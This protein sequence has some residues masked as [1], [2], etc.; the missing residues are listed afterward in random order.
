MALFGWILFTGLFLFFVGF[1]LFYHRNSNEFQIKKSLIWSMLCCS[2]AFLFNL[3]I[4]FFKG[5][6][7]ALE[8]TTGYLVEL[9]L[10]IDNIFVFLLI[11]QHFNIAVQYQHKILSCGVIGALLLRL[12]FILIGLELIHTFHWVLYLFGIFLIVT[13]AAMLKK[14]P[15]KV[16]MKDNFIL[17]I[18]K[19]FF[20][21]QD[22]M[23][24]GYFF[25]RKNGA[26]IATPLFAVLLSVETADLL[27]AFD[28]IPAIFG[29]TV[30]PFIVLTSNGFAV[31]G[32]RSLYFTLYS[33]LRLF[34]YLRHGICIILMFIG[35]K[36]LLE[37]IYK[38]PIEYSLLVI[39]IVLAS[40]IFFSLRGKK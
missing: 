35:L 16:P 15:E 34:T 2:A 7:A 17:R 38:V 3:F 20:P 14:Q 24:N 30:D 31:I 5:K 10:S 32:L 33:L 6:T 9:S 21:F 12:I 18:C 23:E 40:S 26:L 27:F 1:D 37:P 29:V 39:A 13:G 22:T 8:F 11:F 4:Y 36:M 19:K 28:S 25:V